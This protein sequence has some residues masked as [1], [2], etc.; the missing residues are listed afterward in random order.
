MKSNTVFALTGADFAECLIT[1]MANVMLYY[2]TLYMAF[3]KAHHVCLSIYA[4]SY[5]LNYIIM[6]FIVRFYPGFEQFYT[7]DPT[8]TV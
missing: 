1:R 3:D 5:I 8:L 4:Y 7:T 6:E 2:W